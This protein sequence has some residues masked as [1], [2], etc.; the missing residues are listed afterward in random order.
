MIEDSI[1]NAMEQVIE[2][3]I[4]FPEYSNEMPGDN[5]GLLLYREIEKHFNRPYS[6][7]M[8]MSMEEAQFTATYLKQDAKRSLDNA[9]IYLIKAVR[10]DTP[11]HERKM[12]FSIVE[13]MCLRVDLDR[14]IADQLLDMRVV[15]EERES[16]I[17]KA[18]GY[19]KERY[20]AFTQLFREAVAKPESFNPHS[21]IQYHID[22]EDYARA[23][24]LRDAIQES[25][26][27]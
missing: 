4:Q 16:M 24:I 3:N 19:A 7:D 13:E 18:Y 15:P 21:I 1:I 27:A 11:E 14:D 25:V 20:S 12:D 8:K 23:A 22:R 17:K 2:Y 6:R 5:L 26:N 9:E 10:K